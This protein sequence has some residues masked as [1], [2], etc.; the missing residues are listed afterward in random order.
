MSKAEAVSIHYNR[1][2]TEEPPKNASVRDR[3]I[4]S[5]ADPDIAGKAGRNAAALVALHEPVA[6]FEWL[7]SGKGMVL[8]DQH[9]V[10][11]QDLGMHLDR[12]LQ[13]HERGLLFIAVAGG[14]ASVADALKTADDRHRNRDQIGLYHIDDQGRVRRVA[15]RRLPELEK[16]AHELPEIAP[17]TPADIDGIVERGRKERLEAMDFVRGTSRRFPHLTVALIVLCVLFFFASSGGDA[18]ARHVY[19]LLSNRP[20]AIRHGELWRLFTYAL[21]HDPRNATHIIVN[22]LSLYSVGSFLEPLLGRKRLGVLYVACAVAGGLASTLLTDAQ[23]VGASGAVWG[24]MGATLGLLQGRHPFFP[25]LIARS[26]RQRLIVLL[27]INVGISFLPYI[28]RWCHF[29]G[30]VAGYLIGRCFAHRPPRQ[31]TEVKPMT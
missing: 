27:A 6:V 17:L 22:M 9:A 18:R 23:S 10:G 1:D 11:N 19:Q 31:T 21:L 15:G 12:I 25:P 16:A 14:D 2:V 7:G 30:G 13:A 4:A 20:D 8:L 26:L 28:D 3:L 24:L 29:G 5:L